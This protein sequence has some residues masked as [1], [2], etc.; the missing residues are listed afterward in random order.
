MSDTVSETSLRIH[1]F[2]G[3]EA[4]PRVLVLGAVH[5]NEVCGA[6]AIER[7]VR[8]LDEGRLSIARG[9]LTLVPVTNP[10]AAATSLAFRDIGAGVRAAAEPAS[11][12]AAIAPRPP[13]SAR[14]WICLLPAM[15][16]R[17]TT[18]MR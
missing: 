7:V 17:I 6:R 18:T 1:Q 4:G 8:E 15:R 16:V 2:A 10:R 14:R 5:G 13:K 12:L 3:L 11:A 9:T